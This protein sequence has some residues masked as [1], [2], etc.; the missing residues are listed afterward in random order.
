MSDYALIAF[1]AMA[2]I[3]VPEIAIGASVGSMFFLLVSDSETGWRKFSMMLVGWTM[4]YFVASP[5]QATGWAGLISVLG[6]AFAVV[7]MLQIFVSLE[8]PSEGTPVF[9]NWVVDIYKK[10]KG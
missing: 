9:V 4:G 7:I 5:F 10:L 8:N 3:I 1:T 2:A 6:S